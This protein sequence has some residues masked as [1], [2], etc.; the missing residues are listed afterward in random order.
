M[1]QYED[2]QVYFFYFI[3]LEILKQT[4]VKYHSGQ[5]SICSS[6]KQ[7]WQGES[8]QNGTKARKYL[9]SMKNFR[10]RKRNNLDTFEES[11]FQLKFEA[12]YNI[13]ELSGVFCRTVQLQTTLEDYPEN[14]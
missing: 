5:I 3:V 9:Y 7:Q 14:S 10:N 2:G 12:Y 1:K 11:L 6:E 8:V 4:P 13:L